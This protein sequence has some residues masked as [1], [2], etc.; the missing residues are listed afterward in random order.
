M[1]II[2]LLFTGVLSGI[3]SGIFGVSSGI[4]T[5]P[6]L[7]TCFH[8]LGIIHHPVQLAIGTTIAVGTLALA[9][10]SFAQRKTFR[11][12]KPLTAYILIG[13]ACS[14]ILIAMATRYLT[15]H[16]IK[17]VFSILVLILPFITMQ[18]RISKRQQDFFG[19]P[20]TLTLT[21]CIANFVGPA[22]GI[23][24]GI[25]A[26]PFL[27]RSGIPLKEAFANMSFSGTFVLAVLSIL[28]VIL[29]W[30]E[31]LPAYSAGYIYLPA[32]LL[33]GIPTIICA[34]YCTQ[35]RSQ[36]SEKTLKIIF[37]VL[38]TVIGLYML[39]HAISLPHVH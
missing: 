4:V 11:P 21:F 6:L 32:V 25:L 23:G 39:M 31:T 18:E 3:F 28:Y 15:G 9:S 26:T 8:I 17:I 37:C 20:V 29:G 24:G 19:H 30:N 7:I 38:L 27:K 35:L 14:T 13:S 22:F 12:N 2:L 1:G 5:V 16:T 36:L 33:V 10:N 34:K